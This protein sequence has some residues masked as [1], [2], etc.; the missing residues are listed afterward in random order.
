MTT[1]GTFNSVVILE[2]LYSS[3]RQLLANPLRTTLTLSGIMI[4]IASLIAMMGIGE[5]TRVKVIEDM[6]R[7]GGASVL[8]IE[9]RDPANI[10]NDQPG[11]QSETLG[12]RDIEVLKRTSKLI[13]H[14]APVIQFPEAV[15]YRDSHF[16][17]SI[18]GTNEYY[19]VIRDWSVDR[20]RFLTLIDLDNS[21]K[22]VVLGANV[23]ERLFGSENPMA[24]QIHIQGEDYTVVGVMRE[25]DLEGGRWLN[26]LII[27]PLTRVEQMMA[28]DRGY[29]RILL[30]AEKL[31]Y[32]P[33]LK[34]QV[35][36]ALQIHHR[37]PRAILIRSQVEVIDTLERASM[38]MRFSF[39]SITF[40]VLMVG[41][42]GIMNL[43]LVSVTE[44]TREIGIHKAVGAHDLDIVMLFLFESVAMSIIG[45]VVGIVLGVQAGHFLSHTIATQLNNDIAFIVT[46][47]SIM[48]AVIFSVAVGIG[49]GLYPAIKA[50]R[51][52][53]CKALSYE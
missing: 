43:M 5:G 6:D 53:P 33:L 23:A 32:V 10:D 8:G 28:G 40:I 11:Y 35:G 14:I 12:N 29:S 50:S 52:D 36:K 3:L 45:G 16:T 2:T 30:K 25:R 13:S 49:F 17:G 42:I 39:G 4:G 18:L 47:E 26:D 21:S 46:P 38:L 41:G 27:V 31:D 1:R 15:Y 37:N 19:S 34:A 20:G 44:R 22:V 9:L 51:I 48:I 24:N 7:I